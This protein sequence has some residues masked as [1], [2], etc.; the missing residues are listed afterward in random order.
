MNFLFRHCIKTVLL[1]VMFASPLLG[2]QN[3]PLGKWEYTVLE[4][5]EKIGTS[6]VERKL[7]K[8]IIVTNSEL[9]FKSNDYINVSKEVI[10][11]TKSYEP[12]QYRS[13]STVISEEYL[14]RIDLTAKVEDG[15]LFVSDGTQNLKLK[16]NNNIYFGI[17]NMLNQVLQ[18]GGQQKY[19]KTSFVYDPSYNP[20]KVI[21]LTIN[22]IPAST[23]SEKTLN[24]N[25]YRISDKGKTLIDIY[26]NASGV[27][28]RYIIPG[29]NSTIE[30]ILN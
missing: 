8:D 19:S 21:S 23:E 28:Y 22:H 16:F 1:T 2:V 6:L 10:Q 17:N 3:L 13:I 4:N 25:H 20:K 15:V 26:L 29:S 27:I 24:L 9:S 30:L 5:G 11:E 18:T 7:V 12:L 14:K